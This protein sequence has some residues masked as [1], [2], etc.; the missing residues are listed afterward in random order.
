MFQWTEKSEFR[1]RPRFRLTSCVLPHR[2]YYR[3]SYKPQSHQQ[4]T[5]WSITSWKGKTNF[6]AL[7]FGGVLSHQDQQSLPGSVGKCVWHWLPRQGLSKGFLWSALN[8]PLTVLLIHLLGIGHGL[9]LVLNPEKKKR[10][11]DRCL[12][13]TADQWNQDLWDSEVQVLTFF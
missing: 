9:S 2:L 6:Q 8:S 7:N 10:E 3:P 1:S 11:R 12:H 4:Q 5:S 13:S